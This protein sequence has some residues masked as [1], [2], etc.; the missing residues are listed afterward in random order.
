MQEVYRQ[1]RE[2]IDIFNQ[3]GGFVFGSIHNIQ[4]NVPTENLLAMLKALKDSGVEKIDIDFKA[5]SV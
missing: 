3:S 2:R 5:L 1:A 4:S